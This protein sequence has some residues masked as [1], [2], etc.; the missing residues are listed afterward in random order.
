[1]APLPFD[2]QVNVIAHIVN[3][4]SV[5]VTEALTG[6]HR[7]TIIRLCVRVG[8]GCALIHDAFFSQLTVPVIEL[9][10]VWTFVGKKQRR[11][12]PD[13][14]VW[15]GD[16]YVFVAICTTTKTVV[17]YRIGKRNFNTTKDF[18]KDLKSRVVNVPTISS[19][20]F[21][22]YEEAV[23]QTFGD[24]VHYGQILKVFKGDDKPSHGE[25]TQPNNV[26]VIHKLALIGNPDLQKVSTSY[27]ERQ[28]LTMRMN[29]RRMTRKT[30]AFSKKIENHVAAINLHFAYYNL[31]RVH[32]TIKTA[33]AH[34]LGAIDQPWPLHLLVHAAL[35]ILDAQQKAA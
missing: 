30:S 31:C 7:D 28:N 35:H 14:P 18:L 20:S 1:M 34:K 27:V 13:D 4:N 9:D 24:R 10:E 21:Q 17:S 32:E 5:R 19:N 29:I 12:K 25:D 8:T 15:F 16:Q 11:L 3:G 23:R 22:S 6:V 2:Q 33:P 26:A